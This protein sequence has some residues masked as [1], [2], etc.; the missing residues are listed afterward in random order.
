MTSSGPAVS[1]AVPLA[2]VR[3]CAARGERAVREYRRQ[4]A[5]G[6]RR[7]PAQGHPAGVGQLDRRQRLGRVAP[8]PRPG[9]AARSLRRAPTPSARLQKTY[10]DRTRKTQKNGTAPAKTRADAADAHPVPGARHAGVRDVDRRRQAAAGPWPLRRVLPRRDRHRAV[11]RDHIAGPRVGRLRR[12]RSGLSRCPRPTP[13]GG[14]TITDVPE[15]TRDVAFLIDQ[16]PRRVED[17][18]RPPERR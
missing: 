2:L 15:Q 17:R 3:R 5:H 1:P 14:P 18:R 16:A 11:L 10:V 7:Q 6:R 4:G 13:T 8:R 12:G 9:Q